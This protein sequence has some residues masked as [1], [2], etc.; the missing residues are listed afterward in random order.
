MEFRRP[1]RSRRRK[2]PLTFGRPGSVVGPQRPFPVDQAVHGPMRQS[3]RNSTWPAHSSVSLAAQM[4]SRLSMMAE[5]GVRWWARSKPFIGS[6]AARRVEPASLMVLTSWETTIQFSRAAKSSTSGRSVSPG[7]G[8]E[9][10]RTRLP[11]RGAARPRQSR[12]SDHCRPGNAAG[13]WCR[14]AGNLVE[15][16]EPLRHGAGILRGALTHLI[17]EPFLPLQ[18]LM[19]LIPIGQVVGDG[20]VHFLQAQIGI[21]L[22]DG[23]RGVALLEGDHD[24]VERYAQRTHPQRT[25]GILLHV[26]LR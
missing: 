21:E 18:V 15:R 12:H 17:P 1:S 3:G 13:S 10:A 4:S 8:L 22:L 16:A 6:P 14:R 7:R 20:S 23:F 26:P 25:L 2:G 5:T 19:D 24:G 9:A 11:A